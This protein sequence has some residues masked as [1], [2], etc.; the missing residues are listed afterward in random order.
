MSLNV[1]ATGIDFTPQGGSS[2]NLLDDYEEGTF[3]AATDNGS[4][5]D[6]QGVCTYTKIGRHIYWCARGHGTDSNWGSSNQSG[7]ITGLPF[8]PTNHWAGWFSYSNVQNVQHVKNIQNTHY[9]QNAH[10]L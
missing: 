8:T 6:S 9:V 1:T 10:N 5:L 3:T 4:G 2:V 7:K